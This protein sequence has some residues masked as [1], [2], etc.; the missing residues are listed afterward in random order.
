MNCYTIY[1]N[2]YI[3]FIIIFVILS[4]PITA[5]SHPIDYKLFKIIEM[6]ILKDGKKIGFS[7]YLFNYKDGFLVVKNLTEFEVKLLG[8]K[9][10]FIKS[11]GTE[12]YSENQLISFTSSTLQNEK[13]KFVNLKFLKKENEFIIDG[14]SYKGKSKIKS[15]IGNWWNHDILEV[16]SQISPLSG[17]VKEQIVKFL[18]EETLKINNISYNTMHYKLLSKDPNTSDNKKLNFDIWYDKKKNLIV[19]ISYNKFGKWDYQIKN[20]IK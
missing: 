20:F 13:K 18:G 9:V 10:F 16:D 17:S 6:D 1:M 8:V 7:N 14:S 3:K 15:I 19:K 11:E 12:K 4:Y 2:R 5:N